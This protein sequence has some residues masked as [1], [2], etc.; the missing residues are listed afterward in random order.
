MNGVL[1]DEARAEVDHTL[2][3][4]DDR[5]SA[6]ALAEGGTGVLEGVASLA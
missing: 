3:R 1:L 5:Q 2:F 6:G 4:A